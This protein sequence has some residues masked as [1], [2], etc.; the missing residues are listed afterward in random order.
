MRIRDIIRMRVEQRAFNRW[1][2]LMS[3]WGGWRIL[4]ISQIVDVQFPRHFGILLLSS[5]S[6]AVEPCLRAPAE[7]A[8]EG[9]C[10]SVDKCRGMK[11]PP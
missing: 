11:Q 5:T 7:D 10:N 2:T 6:A 3:K 4:R 8:R 1:G 9:A